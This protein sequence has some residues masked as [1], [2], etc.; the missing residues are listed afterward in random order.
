MMLLSL[1][2]NSEPHMN[3]II[4]KRKSVMPLYGQD[5][6]ACEHKRNPHCTG[7]FMVVTVFQIRQPYLL[8]ACAGIASHTDW[9]CH[10]PRSFGA[11]RLLRLPLYMSNYR[12]LG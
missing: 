4:F 11:Q 6:A 5:Q 1:S 7:A 10:L 12:S 9:L 8:H 2:M 3:P